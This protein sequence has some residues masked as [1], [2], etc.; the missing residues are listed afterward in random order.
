VAGVSVISAGRCS[1]RDASV[2]LHSLTWRSSDS[3]RYRRLLLQRNRLRGV[4]AFGDWN[5]SSRA[6][7][8]V[9]RACYIWPWQRRCFLRTGELWPFQDAANVND[10]PASTVVCQCTGVNRGTLSRAILAG[11]RSVEALG[12]QTGASSV[13]GNCKPLLAELAG[14]QASE[15][16]SGSR[17]LVWT[18]MAALLAALAMLFAPSIPFADSVQT[19]CA[20]I[21]YG[22]MA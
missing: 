7:E 18:G 22:V 17:T 14:R 20:G 2:Q 4:I 10:W 6:Q 9:Q 15:P 3:S 8:F 21:A 5:E 19:K 12:G 16:E 1:E 13:C 11:H